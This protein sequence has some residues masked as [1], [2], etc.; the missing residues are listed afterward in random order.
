MVRYAMPSQIKQLPLISELEALLDDNERQLMGRFIQQK[1]Q[2]TYLISHALKRL[3]LA[4]RLDCHP[5]EIRFQATDKGKPFVSYPAAVEPKDKWHFNLSHTEDQV[6]VAVSQ[7]PVGIDVEN[8][9][10]A[11]P[12]LDLAQRYFSGDEY[13][14]LA[15]CEP[16]QRGL[17]FLKLWTLKEAYLK[18]E[19][20]GLSARLDAFAFDVTGPISLT[21]LDPTGAPSRPWQYWQ[22]ALAP[23]FLLSLAFATSKPTED[24]V[25]DCQSWCPQ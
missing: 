9:T 6:A 7:Q 18:A 14:R 5:G 24:A 4:E 10:R 11:L 15:A 12:D 22:T 8:T 3:M 23:S 19:G 17:L 25:I 2:H 20:W 1:H 21:V 13:E 16:D